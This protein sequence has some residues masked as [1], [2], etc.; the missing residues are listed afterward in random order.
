VSRSSTRPVPALPFDPASVPDDVVLSHAQVALRGGVLDQS[1]ACASIVAERSPV[2]ET[3]CEALRLRS[4]ALRLQGDWEGAL[5]SARKEGALAEEAGLADRRAEALNAESAVYLARGEFG[6]AKPLL[7][8]AL[9]VA[10]SPRLLGVLWQNVGLLHASLQ[11][12]SQAEEALHRSR[13]YFDQA[14]DAWGSACTL[15]NQGCV[16][17]DQ[18][19]HEGAT[20]VFA[21]AI[22][23]ARAAND[24]D[25]VAGAMMNQAR[26]FFRLGRFDEAEFH[27]SSAAG[28]FISSKMS[29]RYA[30]CL[31]VLGDVEHARGEVDIARRCWRRGLETAEALAAQGIR[32]EL[33]QRLQHDP[34]HRS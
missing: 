19:D 31:M 32:E 34:D 27:A 9:K 7:E 28:F 10:M 20:E 4:N 30:E 26:A 22:T 5:E 18:D 13:R 6:I 33:L 12:F 29:L 24:L 23:A 25:L 16:R 17:L 2:V 15:I 21:A 8:R 1:L 14:G 3:R 11:E